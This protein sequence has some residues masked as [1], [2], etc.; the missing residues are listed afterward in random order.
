MGERNAGGAARRA[1]KVASSP[2]C[3]ICKSETRDK[4]DQWL[5][6]RG[7]TDPAGQV[8]TWDYLL[9]PMGPIAHLLGSDPPSKTSFRRHLGLTSETSAHTRIVQDG[10]EADELEELTAPGETA[11]LLAEI[12]RLLAGDAPIS[13]T[14]TLSL[15]LRAWALS[16]RRRVALG[17]EITL[18]ADQAQRAASV[19]LK[20]EHQAAEQA[21]LGVLAGGI[22]AA[23]SELFSGDRRSLPRGAPEIVDV[24]PLE[25]ED[26]DVAEAGEGADGG[27]APTAPLPEPP[28][29][30][31]PPLVIEEASEPSPDQPD[32]DPEPVPDEPDEAAG[33]YRKKQAE[34]SVPRR[35]DT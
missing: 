8:I 21:L 9:S 20:S 32:P 12:D 6:R 26:A 22:S 29:R 2:R 35:F 3:S 14:A 30:P 17:E 4:I 27:A 31:L 13:P 15:Q 19:L 1:V 7:E 34:D 33:G 25:V 16:L 5:A 24:E 10:E 23:Y 11:E 28:P 18:T